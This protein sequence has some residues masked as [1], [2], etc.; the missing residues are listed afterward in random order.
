MNMNLHSFAS[1]SFS[2]CAVDLCDFTAHFVLL[3]YHRM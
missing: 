1:G 2:K 3:W